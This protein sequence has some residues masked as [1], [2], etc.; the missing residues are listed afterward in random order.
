MANNDGGQGWVVANIP[1][2]HILV[3]TRRTVSIYAQ[4]CV[5][6]P[7]PPAAM[8]WKPELALQLAVMNMMMSIKNAT[9]EPPSDTSTSPRLEDR[10]IAVSRSSVETIRLKSRDI[11]G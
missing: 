8:G 5:T 2:D 11:S 10:W 9:V 1:Y 6:A 3:I 7:S 4:N